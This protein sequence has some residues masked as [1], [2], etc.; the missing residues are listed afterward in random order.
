MVVV[1]GYALPLALL[2]VLAWGVWRIVRRTG[3]VPAA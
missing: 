2:A 1:L 3:T